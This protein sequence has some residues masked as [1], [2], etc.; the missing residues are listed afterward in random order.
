MDLDHAAANSLM[1]AGASGANRPRRPRRFG[2][3]LGLAGLGA[4]GGAGMAG[5]EN[6]ME[7][8]F[9]P[10]RMQVPGGLHRRADVIPALHDRRR[11]VPH[12]VDIGE[13]LAVAFEKA[14]MLKVMAFDAREGERESVR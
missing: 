3:C 10:G 12:P 6:E 11:N 8:G 4:P 2:L 1:V 7:L 14:P 13:E 5:V 9:R